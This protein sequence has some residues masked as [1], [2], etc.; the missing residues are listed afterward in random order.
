MT[1]QIDEDMKCTA[2]MRN[3]IFVPDLSCSLFS[4][5]SATADVTKSVSFGRNGVRITDSTN[6]LIAMGSLNDGAYILN[7]TVPVPSG[8]PRCS[9]SQPHNVTEEE[10]NAASKTNNCL[11]AGVLA[12][13]WHRRFGHLAEQNMIKLINSDHV[14]DMAVAKQDMTFCETCVQG[15]AHQQPIR[16]SLT[17]VRPKYWT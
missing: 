4:I 14:K 5:K 13:V 16:N 11:V 17:I 2:D 3:C 8:R 12:D 10:S 15:K 1:V 6:M 7:C 9:E